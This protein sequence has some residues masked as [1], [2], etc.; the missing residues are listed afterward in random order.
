MDNVHLLYKKLV[1]NKRKT[2][3]GKKNI[4][5]KSETDKNTQQKGRSDIVQDKNLHKPYVVQL[6]LIN[7]VKI[8]KK[9]FFT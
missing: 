4:V 3:S 1:K 5:R 2:D 8:A 9:H 6:I 7:C